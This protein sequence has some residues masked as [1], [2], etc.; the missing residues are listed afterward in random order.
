MKI[1]F[2]HENYIETNYENIVINSE[3]SY[4]TSTRKSVDRG[5]WYYEV[6]HL[7][8]SS[9]SVAGFCYSSRN[10][11]SVTRKDNNKNEFAYYYSV[12]KQSSELFSTNVAYTEMH[13]I[14][15]GLDIDNK[16]FYIR[17]NKDDVRIYKFNESYPEN[18]VWNVMLRSRTGDTTDNIYNVNFGYKDFEYDI[19]FGFTSWSN[20]LKILLSTCSKLTNFNFLSLFYILILL[21]VP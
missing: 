1:Y 6:T 8:G 19:P 12:N 11:I 10:Q 4:Y 16:M 15:L 9:L 7:S 20:K 17:F 2:K 13:T 21:N 14:G 18:I 3:H 5:S